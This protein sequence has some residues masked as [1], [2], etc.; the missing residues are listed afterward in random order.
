M[1]DDT[2]SDENVMSAEEVYQKLEE[3][4]AQG[5]IDST[6]EDLAVMEGS[7]NG[8]T[9]STTVRCGMPGNPSASQALYEVSV[10]MV[11]GIA[12]QTR[13]LLPDGKVEQFS[14]RDN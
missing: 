1:Q 11:T 14:L 2:S 12:S 9:Y 8:T 5:T 7:V 10:D 13:M 3:H 4:Y 6:G